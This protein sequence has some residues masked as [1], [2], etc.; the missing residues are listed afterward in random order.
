[1]QEYFV[2]RAAPHEVADV[3]VALLPGNVWFTLG[4][5]YPSGRQVGILIQA[6]A[7]ESEIGETNAD[8]GMCE[9]LYRHYLAKPPRPFKPEKEV[10]DASA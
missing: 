2:R 4:R 1:M 9:R 5:N 7:N 8:Q 6:F 10:I 3:K